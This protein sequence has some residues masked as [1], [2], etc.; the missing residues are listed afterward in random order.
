MPRFYQPLV[1]EYDAYVVRGDVLTYR[2]RPRLDRGVSIYRIAGVW[3]A[4]TNLSELQLDG[5]DRIY[6]GGYEYVVPDDELAEMEAQS[7][8]ACG[9]SDVFLD[10]FTETF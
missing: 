6:Y 3:Y 7:F 4:G 10:Q 1:E 8:P 5:A 2:Y 9:L